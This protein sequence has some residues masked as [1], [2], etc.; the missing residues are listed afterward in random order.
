MNTYIAT[1]T[2]KVKR[3]NTTMSRHIAV[4]AVDETSAYVEARKQLS[5]FVTR[6]RA[7]ILIDKVDKP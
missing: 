2:W 1:A 3:A 5:Q 4:E 6:N 7:Y